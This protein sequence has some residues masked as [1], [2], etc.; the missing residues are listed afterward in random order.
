LI[1]PAV[2]PSGAGD[3]DRGNP[4][5]PATDDLPLSGQRIMATSDPSDEVKLRGSQ[6]IVLICPPGT[7]IDAMEPM[8]R[9]TTYRGSCRINSVNSSRAQFR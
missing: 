3:R 9:R 2:A 4:C 5:R 6:H 1:P 8:V 7:A